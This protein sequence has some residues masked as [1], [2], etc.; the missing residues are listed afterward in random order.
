M[1]LGDV[2]ITPIPQADGRIK[3]RPAVLL[4]EL[5]PFGDVLVC[6]ISSQVQRE[7]VGFD[8][9]I[10][11]NDSDFDISGL[12]TDSLNRLGFLSVLP[13]K[14]IIGTI[15]SLSPERHRRLLQNLANH[16]LK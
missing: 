11:I 12:K 9:I 7:V 5:P 3:N 14:K 16:L 2:I 1:K 8:E 6:G 15:G 13:V 10:Q 4:C